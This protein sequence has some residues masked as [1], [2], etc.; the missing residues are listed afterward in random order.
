MY[1]RKPSYSGLVRRIAL[2]LAA[3]AAAALGA[4]GVARAQERTLSFT[5]GP[6]SVP[7]YSVVQQPLSA[8]SPA[9]DGHVV[10][11]DAEVVDAAGRVQ[12]RDRVMLH[13]IVFAKV[14]VP[15]YTCGGFTQRFFAEGEERLALALP[16]GY[17]YP[18]RAT[19]R[20][21]LLYMLM[22]HRPE[23]LKGYIRYRVRYSPG[24]R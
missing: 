15:D 20:W 3:L 23:T 14:G 13:H 11:M 16:R 21:A 9:V 19:D 2:V 1:P 4:P 18:N 22:N 12:G 8:K 6:I 5:T 10:G 7:G 17:G 24:R